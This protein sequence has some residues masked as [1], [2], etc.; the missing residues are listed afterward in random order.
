MTDSLR[1]SLPSP[2]G[3]DSSPED[4]SSPSN[5]SSLPPAQPDVPAPFRDAVAALQ[6]QVHTAEETIRALRAENE[7]L[8]EQVDRLSKRPDV[9][10]DDAFARFDEDRDALRRRIQHF[11]DAIDDHLATTPASGVNGPTLEEAPGVEQPLDESST[12]VEDD[13]R[14]ADTQGEHRFEVTNA[15]EE[16]A[17]TEQQ[18]EPEHEAELNGEIETKTSGAVEPGSEE[19]DS[20]N[21]D[22]SEHQEDALADGLPDADQFEVEPLQRTDLNAQPVGSSATDDAGTSEGETYG[23]DEGASERDTP[24]TEPRLIAPGLS[25]RRS[26]RR[27]RR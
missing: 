2:S 13:D 21:P 25:P 12:P 18:L 7:Q 27:R 19:A 3:P 23:G 11:I 17:G 1:P 9:T 4:A 10:D 26:A 6:K 22:A 24:S 8:R 16:S 20:T 15:T 14:D 5:A